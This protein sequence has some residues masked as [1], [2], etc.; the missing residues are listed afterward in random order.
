MACDGLMKPRLSAILFL[1]LAM[2][3]AALANVTIMT[4]SLPN[5]TVGT[6]YSA[7]VTAKNGC[8]PYI[9]SVNGPLP[10]G[11]SWNV[12]ANSNG[13]GVLSLAGTPTTAASYPFSIS[14]EGCGKHVSTKGYTVV[15]QPAAQ[16]VGITVS[17]TSATVNAGSAEQFS[18]YVRGTTN[19]AVTWTASG[20]TVSANGLYTAPASAGSYTVTAT[21]QA[22]TT[23]SATATVTVQAVQAVAVSVSPS[24]ASIYVDGTE[25]FSA[26]V[27][28]TT[29]TA[30]TWT[31][32]GGTVSSGGLYTAPTAA[33]T[34]TVK[35][36][37]QADTTKSAVATVTVEPTIQHS[38]TLTWNESESVASFN[39]LRA[40]GTNGSFV[41]IGSS[42]T[43]SY[44]DKTVVSGQTYE[45]VTT[46]VNS[47]GDESAH[48]NQAPATI[49]FP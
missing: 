19:T 37:S 32:S 38:V 18:A 2:T 30:V 6:P 41:K 49:P 27:T 26:Y 40:T 29:N 34:Y 8:T 48:S 21:S 16:N 10:A 4:T 1:L 15:I 11:V 5:G 13:I 24:A 14:V 39:V 45:Y 9:W 7:S 22:D 42:L 35:A 46:A 20:G 33:G 28:G 23:K 25:Q 12:T 36:T 47:T 17:P 3:Q 31:A 44:V 43:T